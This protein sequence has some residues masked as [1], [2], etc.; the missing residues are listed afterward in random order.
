[1]SM[2]AAAGASDASKAEDKM[3]YIDNAA[4]RAIASTAQAVTVQREHTVTRRF[5]DPMRESLERVGRANGMLAKLPSAPPPDQ[6]KP[7]PAPSIASPGE[8]ARTT[9]ARANTK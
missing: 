5:A 4:M 6:Q 9:V 7:P 2:D 8:S 3:L 1:M